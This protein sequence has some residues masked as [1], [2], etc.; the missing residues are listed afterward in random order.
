MADVTHVPRMHV[1]YGPPASGKSVWVN[2]LGVHEFVADDIRKNLVYLVATSMHGIVPGVV[3]TSRATTREEVIHQIARE[4]RGT[5]L[6]C[7]DI[8]LYRSEVAQSPR[9]NDGAWTAPRLEASGLRVQRL[10]PLTVDEMRA[11]AARAERL[12]GRGAASGA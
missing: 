5:Q 2:F 4:L 9:A 10:P 1:V 12:R 6:P 11:M 7:L 3:Y 8:D